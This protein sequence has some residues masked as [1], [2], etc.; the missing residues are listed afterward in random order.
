MDNSIRVYHRKNE[1][2]KCL[3]KFLGDWEA[4]NDNF[5]QLLADKRAHCLTWMLPSCDNNAM[6]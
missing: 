1:K 3:A 2:G 4:V 5:D 6:P